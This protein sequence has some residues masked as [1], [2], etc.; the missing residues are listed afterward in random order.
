MASPV[1][2][3][4]ANGFTLV[5]LLV[6]IAIIGILV[7]LLLP[8][9]QAARESARR[10][11]CQNNLKQLGLG[12]L[13]YHDVNKVFAPGHTGFDTNAATDFQHSWMTLILSH[14]EH[15]ALFDRYDL[16]KRWNQGDN[17]RFVTRSPNGNLPLQLCPSSDHVVDAQ[18]DYAGINGPGSYNH[19]GIVIPDGY[20]KGM[21]YESGILIA[22]G[23]HPDT[24]PNRPIPV[25]RVTDGTQYTI[26]IGEDSARNDV[27]ESSG[28]DA[29][30]GGGGNDKF[31]GYA[32]QT[33]AH[34]SPVLN[35]RNPDGTRQHNEM[36]SDHPGGLN[37]VFADGHVKW[38]NDFTSHRI[39][40]F[41]TT[42]A[43]GELMNED[44]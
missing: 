44:F 29:G 40:D 18:G 31:W 34:H 4:K 33:F 11:Q 12:M 14:V 38:L 5:E 39:I 23:P 20:Q 10:S 25:A 9:V 3:R 6:V 41:M 13:L 27:T 30:G 1:S 21:G 2:K 24:K 32:H 43:T 26:L 19:D 22:V 15:Q 42:R 7:A 37:S 8:A 35:P 36:G 28:E 16:N 17:G